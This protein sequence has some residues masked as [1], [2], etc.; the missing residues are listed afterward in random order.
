MC[1]KTTVVLAS[2]VIGNLE[3]YRSV[4]G[5]RLGH[6]WGKNSNNSG[7]GWGMAGAWLGQAKLRR[8]WGMVG[9]QGM[10]DWLGQVWGMVES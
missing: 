7:Q 1:I 5:S 6:G 2:T 10:V 3:I 9:A 8:G 4:V